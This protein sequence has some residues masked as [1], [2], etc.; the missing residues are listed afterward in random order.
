MDEHNKNMKSNYQP[1]FIPYWAKNLVDFGTLTQNVIGAHVDP[2]K[3]TFF[4]RLYFGPWG[5]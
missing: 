1:Q 3:W 4:G 2:P 5:C